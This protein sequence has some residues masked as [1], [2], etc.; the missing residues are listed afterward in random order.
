MGLPAR[1]LWPPRYI[2]LAVEP[3]SGVDRL[4]YVTGLEQC[5]WPVLCPS[6]SRCV[7]L[8]N[9]SGSVQTSKEYTKCLFY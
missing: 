7:S 9:V 4:N 8:N 2:E 5:P 6:D 3:D 1:A